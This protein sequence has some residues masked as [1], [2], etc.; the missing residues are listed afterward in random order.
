MHET[1]NDERWKTATKHS[2]SILPDVKD[3]DGMFKKIIVDIE[4]QSF[5]NPDWPSP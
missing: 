5:D 3:I 2:K 1:W 4:K